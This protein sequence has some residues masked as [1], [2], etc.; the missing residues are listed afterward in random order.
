MDIQNYLS[1]EDP[2]LKL[3][4]EENNLGKFSGGV[5]K[6]ESEDYTTEEFNKIDDPLL[7]KI[8]DDDEE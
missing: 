8:L 4:N 6:Y 7:K 1:T 2:N 5:T 3:S